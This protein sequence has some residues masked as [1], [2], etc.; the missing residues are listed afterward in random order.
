MAGGDEIYDG[1]CKINVSNTLESQLDLLA[2]QM[3]LE[4]REPCLVQMPVGGFGTEPG[5]VQFIQGC[6]LGAADICVAPLSV[7]ILAISGYPLQLMPNVNRRDGRVVWAG[8][9]PQL[10]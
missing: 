1:D 6:N 2:Q 5:E 4:P 3:M 8:S 9:Q 10:I 7:L